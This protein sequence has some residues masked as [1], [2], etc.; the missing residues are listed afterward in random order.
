MD[1]NMSQCYIQFGKV[2]V[3]AVTYLSLFQNKGST[4][5]LNIA[6]MSFQG[7]KKSL[8]RPVVVFYLECNWG[9]LLEIYIIIFFIEM[10]H[11]K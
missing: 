4:S 8:I 7:I 6:G 5:D 11:Y 9:T 3:T 2:L 10:A 1:E